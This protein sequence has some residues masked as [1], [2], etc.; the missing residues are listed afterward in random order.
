MK[1]AG[2]SVIAEPMDVIDLGTMA[3]FADPSGAVFGVWQPGTFPGAGLVNEPGALSWNELNTRDVA[4]A[5]EFYGAVFGW[6]FEDQDMGETGTYT[7]ISLGEQHG[8]RH[9]RHDRTRCP[10]AG[11]GPLAGL[12]RRRGHR[13]GGRAGQ[14]SAAAA[15]WSSRW[16]VPA[17]RFAILVDPHG[18]S[19]AVITLSE[20]M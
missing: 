3:V 1:E 10:R 11:P 20:E 14:A 19:F 5:K 12:L 2:G 6:A 15:S 4:G 7:T 17:G 16:T 13:R 18:A 8:R 9:P